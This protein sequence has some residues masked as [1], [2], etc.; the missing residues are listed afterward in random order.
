[1]P[2]R[3]GCRG[4]SCAARSP[5]PRAGSVRGD[6]DDGGADL[7]A[8]L[9]VAVGLDDVVEGVRAVEDGSERP[10][11]EPLPEVLEHLGR[12]HREGED[13]PAPTPDPRDERER[14]VL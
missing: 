8:A 4:S 3:A 9:D 1:M 13:D 10:A 2:W 12:L 6:L 5:D 14:D 11:V 7:L